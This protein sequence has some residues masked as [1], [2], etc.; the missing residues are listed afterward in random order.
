[1]FLRGQRCGWLPRVYIYAAVRLSGEVHMKYEA[2]QARHLGGLFI[3]HTTPPST[4][5]GCPIEICASSPSTDLGRHGRT[6]A[7]LTIDYQAE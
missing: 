3:G 7:G 6:N 4:L 5:C 1:M 2:S